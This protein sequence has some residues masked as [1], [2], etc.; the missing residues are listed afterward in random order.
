MLVCYTCFVF[1]FKQKTAYEMRISD[2]SSDVCSSDLCDAQPDEMDIAIAV[3]RLQTATTLE[4]RR[5]AAR[6]A[7]LRSFV[8]D[9]TIVC[10]FD[11]ATPGFFWLAAQGGYGIQTSAAMSRVSGA[12]ALGRGLPD[13]VAALGVTEADLTPASRR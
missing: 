4:V 10:G 13:D 11:A 3:D 1:F 2:W 8:A 9:R 5:L 12:L 6:W 7:G